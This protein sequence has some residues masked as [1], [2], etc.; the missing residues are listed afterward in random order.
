MQR[1]WCHCC[2]QHA[3]QVPTCDV[4]MPARARSEGEEQ[5]DRRAVAAK[6]AEDNR[7]LTMLKQQERSLQ[8]Q[9]EKQQCQGMVTQEVSGPRLRNALAWCPPL[10]LET[11][12]AVARLACTQSAARGGPAPT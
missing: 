8:Q 12:V 9:Q 1:R 2:T 5:A 3:C 6:V 7:L 4:W 11:A 10:V